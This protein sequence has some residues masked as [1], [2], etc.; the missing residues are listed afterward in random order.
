MMFRLSLLLTNE[1]HSLILV[2]YRLLTS[3]KLLRPIYR[4][5]YGHDFDILLLKREGNWGRAIDFLGNTTLIF[6]KRIVL[7]VSLDLRVPTRPN[8]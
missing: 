3:F 2:R 8:G 6:N 5:R 1:T 4:V 7:N